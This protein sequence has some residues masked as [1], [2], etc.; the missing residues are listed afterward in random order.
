MAGLKAQS[1]KPYP[2]G[3]VYDGEGVNFA[4]FSANAKIFPHFLHIKNSIIFSPYF[5]A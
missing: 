5:G 1:G 4:L 3:A 2:L